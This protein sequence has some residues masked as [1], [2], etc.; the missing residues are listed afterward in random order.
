MSD[1]DKLREAIEKS[2]EAIS[3]ISTGEERI[4]V[5]PF[6]RGEDFDWEGGSGYTHA[7]CC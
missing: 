1:F 5:D 4:F 7:G 3:P 6:T 2:Q